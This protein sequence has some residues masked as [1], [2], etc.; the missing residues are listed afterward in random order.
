MIDSLVDNGATNVVMGMAHRCLLFYMRH[1]D[2]GDCGVDDDHD[3][4]HCRP[5]RHY[6]RDGSRN[7]AA[8]SSPLTTRSQRQVERTRQCPEEA[9]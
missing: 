7:P 9:C 5:C 6:R 1:V 8:P 3:E 4:Q 2:G